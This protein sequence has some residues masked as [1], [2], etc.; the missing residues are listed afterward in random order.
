MEV[1]KAVIPAAG[2]GTRFLP[3]T[4]ASPKEML[5]LVDKPIIQAVVEEAVRSGLR[6]VILIT[7]RGKRAIEDHF[8]VSAELENALTARGQTELLERIRAISRMADFAYIRQKEPKGL[9]H[10]ILTASFA[11]G[12]SPF[13]VLLGDDIIDG[14][15]PCIRQLMRVFA[16]ERRAVVALME[17]P[18]SEVHRYGII[19]GDD[20]GGGLYRVRR[21]VEKPRRE[22]APSN[23]AVI[24]RYVL[25]PS[26][27]PAIEALTPGVGQEYQLTDA[28]DALA[29]GE[30]VFGL[31]FDGVRHDAGDRLGF[32]KANLHFA[33]KDPELAPPLRE[34]LRG[35]VREEEAR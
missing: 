6:E 22:E 9:G 8:D 12:D 27:F 21:L 3:V 13:A 29:R 34:H 4:K 23:L 28:L 16:R 33:L 18:D 7:G 25:P 17:V 15:D 20:L 5:P 2:M 31:V 35:L 1:R 26:V 30:G 19:E 11:V 32:L 24:G 14:P 10:A